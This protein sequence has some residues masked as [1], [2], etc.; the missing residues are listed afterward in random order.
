MI[1]DILILLLFGPINTVEGFFLSRLKSNTN[2]IITKCVAR[3]AAKHEGTNLKKIPFKR[4]HGEIIELITTITTKT[5]STDYRVIGFWNKDEKES[6]WYI[7]NLLVPAKS[8]YTLYR[9]RWQIELIFKGCKQSFNGNRLATS[10]N[11]NIVEGLLYATI[12]AQIITTKFIFIGIETL[13][14]DQKNTV[15][16]QRIA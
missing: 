4:K 6:H 16:F 12:A 15:S 9:F 3:L 8:M 13:D 11:Q 14:T 7:T 10:N 5:L 1:W 2:I